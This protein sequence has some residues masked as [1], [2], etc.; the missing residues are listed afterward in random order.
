[1]N[2]SLTKCIRIIVSVSIFSYM[3]AMCVINLWFRNRFY[4]FHFN[5]MLC[6]SRLFLTDN[7]NSFN[8]F[9]EL[10]V[11]E[12]VSVL[13]SQRIVIFF[14][15]ERRTVRSTII[16]LLLHLGNLFIFMLHLMYLRMYE[17]FIL[18]ATTS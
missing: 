9:M 2:E 10:Y 17:F 8:F 7:R 14:N 3:R 16:M 5:E 12:L 4:Y 18:I 6:D 1:M 13:C 11:I 15:C